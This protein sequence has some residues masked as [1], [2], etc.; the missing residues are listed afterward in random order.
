M[1]TPVSSLSHVPLAGGMI[2]APPKSLAKR[3]PA[4]EADNSWSGKSFPCLSLLGMKRTNSVPFGSGSEP[5]K[6]VS[7][8]SSAPWG[9]RS[10]DA[11]QKLPREN[12]LCHQV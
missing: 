3:S 8:D 7:V 2:V 1:T 11:K 5:S 4:A 12:D 9:L 6:S 10:G